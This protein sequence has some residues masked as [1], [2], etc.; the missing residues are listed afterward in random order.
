MEMKMNRKVLFVSIIILIF[1]I[2]G[3]G[4]ASETIMSEMQWDHDL[5][6]LDYKEFEPP[7][8][9]PTYCEDACAKDDKCVA[10]TYVKPH[11]IK[12]PRPRCFL[13][14]AL[15][16]LEPNPNCVSGYKMQ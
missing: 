11:T 15:P 4:G 7:E 5:K 13:K 8:A 1:G 2:C 12:G 16:Q 14:N 9:D 3:Y 10:W 6:S